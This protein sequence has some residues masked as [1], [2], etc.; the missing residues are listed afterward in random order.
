FGHAHWNLA[1]AL[2]ATRAYAEGWREYEYRLTLGELGGNAPAMALPRWT[3]T[4]QEG[5]TIVLGAEQGLGDTIQFARFARPLADAGMRVILQVP[6]AMTTLLASAPGV[7][8]TLAHRH[9]AGDADCALPLL[10]VA[11]ALGVTEASLAGDV[12]Y[13]HPEMPRRIAVRARL[14]SA[15]IALKA[16]LAWAGAPGHANDRRRSLPFATLRPLLDAPG[17]TWYSLQKDVTAGAPL[18]ELEARNNLD[19]IA[20]LIAEL[21]LVVTVDTGIAHLAGALGRPT[22]ILLPYAPDWRW[23]LERGDSPWYPTVRLFRQP[24]PGDW[25]SVLDAVI[26][27]LQER[28]VPAHLR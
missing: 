20:A 1:L 8:A 26:D 22:W 6:Q 25:A 14:G 24:R 2:L 28:R 15:R 18:I 9:P 21:D 27:A 10:S 17:I 16:G 11:G 4:L 7:A 19:D 12:P 23:Q 13:L 3:G 5:R